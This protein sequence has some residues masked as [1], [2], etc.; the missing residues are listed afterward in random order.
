MDTIARLEEWPDPAPTAA[1]GAPGRR[2]RY[3]WARYIA[4]GAALGLGWGVLMRI[5]MRFISTSPEFSWTGT[6]FILGA[7]AIA[8]AVLGFARHRRNA[9]GQGWWRLSI[10]SLLLLGAAGGV[11]WGTVILWGAAI[12]RRRTWWLALPLTIAG[13]LLQIPVVGDVI[14]DGWR[15]GSV[16]AVVAVGWYAPMLAFEAWAF[17]VVFAL[18]APGVDTPRW[19][20]AVIAVPI[21]AVSLLAVVVAGFMG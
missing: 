6:M 13:A 5:W 3:I 9:G 19:K 16:A 12:A 15:R 10:L 17:S 18:S 14:L 21:A 20:T 2:D 1:L 11:M 4:L 8:G 7:S